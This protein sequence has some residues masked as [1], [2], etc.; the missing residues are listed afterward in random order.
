MNSSAVSPSATGLGADHRAPTDHEGGQQPWA[1]MEPEPEP[2]PMV[3]ESVQEVDA[4]VVA[5]AMPSGGVEEVKAEVVEKV[6]ADTEK[7]EAESRS[8]DTDAAGDKRPSEFEEEAHY[9][10]P[11]LSEKAAGKLPAAPEEDDDTP[12]LKIKHE[13]DAAMAERAL[14]SKERALQEGQ[15][16]KTEDKNTKFTNTL[17]GN[18]KIMK[19]DGSTVVVQGILRTKTRSN[20]GKNGRPNNPY[21]HQR[22]AAKEAIQAKRLLLCHD[23]GLGKTFTLLLIIAAMHVIDH[24]R[25]RKVLLSAPA[26]CLDQLLSACLDS[27]RIPESNILKTNELKKLNARSIRA[28]DIIIV[29]RETLTGAFSTC[30]EWQQ[31]HHQNERNNWCSGYGRIDG[32]TLHPIFEVA[33]DL[34]GIDEVHCMQCRPIKSHISVHVSHP[35]PVPCSHLCLLC[36]FSYAQPDRQAHKGTRARLPEGQQGGRP[37][38][39]AHLQQHHRRLGTLHRHGHAPTLQGQEVVVRGQGHP[40]RQHA[41][42]QGV[43]QALEPCH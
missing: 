33:F 38:R 19:K 7:V 8:Q 6:A 18:T 14:V 34:F 32:S 36:A 31:R 17:T 21:K 27:L 26:S 2:E 15:L 20:K 22:V 1:P 35:F 39:L 37:E 4:V 41:D 9:K 28:N 40:L 24:G 5:Y 30:F 10:R 23:P 3:T 25:R 29:S 12:S 42:R 43:R 16:S 13:M 11:K